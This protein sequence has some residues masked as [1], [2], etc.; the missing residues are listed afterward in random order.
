MLQGHKVYDVMTNKWSTG[1]WIPLYSGN[2]LIQ[3]VP[4]WAD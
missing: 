4:V 3:Y 2:V 1:Y